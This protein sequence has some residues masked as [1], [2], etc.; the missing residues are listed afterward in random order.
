MFLNNI[1]L[2]FFSASCFE[3]N[4]SKKMYFLFRLLEIIHVASCKMGDVKCIM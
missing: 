4:G 3:F 2:Q 1:N